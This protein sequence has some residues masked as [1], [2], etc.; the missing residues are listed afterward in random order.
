MSKG[1]KKN[2]LFGVEN[3]LTLSDENEMSKTRELFERHIRLEKSVIGLDLQVSNFVETSTNDDDPDPKQ[4]D[5]TESMQ[6]KLSK[7][8]S[9]CPPQ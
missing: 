3:L 8:F 2:E 6:N 4:E 7:V 5:E 1:K 9:K